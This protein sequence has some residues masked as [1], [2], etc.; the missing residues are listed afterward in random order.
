MHVAV[1]AAFDFEAVFRAHYR[2]VARVIFRIVQDPSRAEELAVDVFW[3]L[4]RHASAQGP[5]SG[6]WLYRTAVRV[7]I[8]ELRARSS[9]ERRERWFGFSAPSHNPEQAHAEAEERARIRTVLASLRRQDAQLIAL[10]AEGLS[11][12]E[13]AEV[14]S[15]NAASIGTLLRRAHQSFRK[16][17]VTRYG[18]A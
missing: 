4:W 2:R 10:R 9:R 11:Y 3:K 1:T 6:A 8:D 18:D 7:A 15:L 16:E 5:H 17:Y 14:L 13:L 12:Q